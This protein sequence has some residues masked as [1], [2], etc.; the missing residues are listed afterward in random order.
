MTTEGII[1]EL[2]KLPLTEKLLVIEETLKSIR[3]AKDKQLKLAVKELYGE[4]KSG[5][6]LTEFT[7]LDSEPF[8]ETR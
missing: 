8:Y 7:L 1:R 3:T 5:S 6:H 2:D 4:Y